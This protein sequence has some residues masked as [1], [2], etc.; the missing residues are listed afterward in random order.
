MTPAAVPVSHGHRHGAAADHRF[1]HN[2]VTMVVP[3]GGGG[4]VDRLIDWPV[5]W[6]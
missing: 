4:G 1:S 3:A 6:P 2:A 5:R